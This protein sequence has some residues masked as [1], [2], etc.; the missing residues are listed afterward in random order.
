MEIHC[1]LTFV[2]SQGEERTG[3]RAVLDLV[4]RTGLLKLVQLL[5]L[6]PDL[7][8]DPVALEAVSCLASECQAHAS[9]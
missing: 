2:R 1:E 5:L 7:D 8:T 9:F 3:K 4:S 6:I